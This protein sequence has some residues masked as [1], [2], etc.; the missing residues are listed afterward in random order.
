MWNGEPAMR[1]AVLTLSLVLAVFLI[2][3]HWTGN[4]GPPD[5]NPV[6]REAA[7]AIGRCDAPIYN[8]YNDGGFLIWFV[9]ERKV[10]LDS[11]QDPYPI[12][13]I[14]AQ[15]RTERTGESRELFER[16]AIGC[17]VLR[18]DSTAV[19]AL[20]RAGWKVTYH[21]AQWAVVEPRGN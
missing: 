16:Y 19:T 4:P 12:E 5:W 9:P 21:D 17:A 11:R 13:L 8:H 1:A 20:Q 2:H 7:L 6:S 10:F 3:R 18:P 14:Q 15:L